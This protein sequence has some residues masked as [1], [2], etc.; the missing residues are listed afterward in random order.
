[1][2]FCWVSPPTYSSPHSCVSTDTRQDRFT[3]N[4]FLPD[5][6]YGN[7]ASGNYTLVSGEM[8]LITGAYTRLPSQTTGNIYGVGEPPNTSML[9]IPTPWTS[10]GVG[11]AIPA[12]EVGETSNITASSSTATRT[13]TLEST[14]I[15]VSIS[16]IF[17]AA[18]HTSTP[19]V[20][21]VAG[22]RS[23]SFTGIFLVT[24]LIALV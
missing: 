1:V 23:A 3:T 14:S 20:A 2:P 13:V 4:Y 12:S 10:K 22:S 21:S 7:V 5:D 16:S 18:S 11:I 15:S 6:S 8:N 17:D 24:L 9:S 19:T